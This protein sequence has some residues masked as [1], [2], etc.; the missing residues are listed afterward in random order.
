M[1][2]KLGVPR[3]PKEQ[4]NKLQQIQRSFLI[5]IK[6]AHRTVSQEALSAIAGIM[7][8]NQAMHLYKY[9]RAISRSQPT[10]AVIPDL[11]KIEIPIKTRGIHPKD[12][13]I[14][15]NLSGTDCSANV[16]IYTDGSKTESHVRASM[17][18][19]KNSTEIHTETQR[20]NITCTTFQAELCRIILL[21]PKPT[22]ENLLLSN[23]R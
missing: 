20:L 2:Q 4:K 1:P 13:Y 14:R 12:S 10:Y 5:F 18:A 6:K 17:V 22:A 16:S 3:Y 9:I 7:S 8:L 11:K 23:Q 21:D 19:V 15:V